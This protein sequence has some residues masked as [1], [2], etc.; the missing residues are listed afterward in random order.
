MLYFGEAVA[1]PAQ[2]DDLYLIE[3]WDTI[4]APESGM[5]IPIAVRNLVM[6]ETEG[7]AWLVTDLIQLRNTR[8]RTI[9][10]G[11]GVVWS[12]EIPPSAVNVRVGQGDLSADAIEVR[13]GRVNVL[14]PIPPGERIVLIRYTLEELPAEIPV[15]TFTDRIDILVQE[16]ATAIE[17]T[18][19]SALGPVDVEG[20]TYRLY[21]A[22]GVAPTT[23]SLETLQEGGSI[24][25][26]WL[27]V[28][29][30]LV[31]SAAGLWV[32]YRPST[33]TAAAAAGGSAVPTAN[34]APAPPAASSQQAPQGEEAR[35]K[36]LVEV[37][38]VDEA[39]EAGPD[40]E[41]EASLKERRSELMNRLRSLH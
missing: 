16:P 35:R 11:G 3:T 5:E 13:E 40:A 15:E 25:V 7:G 12:H 17:A 21:S 22:E 30:G 19:L 39:L 28:L 32:Y 38:R 14:A 27:A 6:E 26:G 41:E 29:F 2:L 18:P 33:A 24:P 31:L 36:L 20:T 34:A 9:V 23:I 1:T 37:A 8:D 4:G 10:A